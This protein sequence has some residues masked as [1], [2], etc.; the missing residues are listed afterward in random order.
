MSKASSS[1][2][3]SAAVWV[4]VMR[5]P[6][7]GFSMVCPAYAIPGSFGVVLAVAGKLRTP[8]G[9]VV[10]LAA[11]L[12]GAGRTRC[13]HPGGRRVVGR[14]AEPWSSGEPAGEQRGADRAAEVAQRRQADRGRSFGG[15]QVRLHGHT[16]P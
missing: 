14:A 4:K 3:V 1:P 12:P 13:R 15:E 10:G 5:S 16:Q 6:L 2:P 11:D 9:P 8:R 7:T